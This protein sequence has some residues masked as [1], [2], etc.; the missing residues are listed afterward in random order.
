V[1]HAAAVGGVTGGCGV[2]HA[3][4]AEV[5]RVVGGI[6][7]CLASAPAVGDVLG[8]KRRGGG[9]LGDVQAVAGVVVGLDQVDLAERADRRDHVDVEGFLFGP[10]TSGVR[11]GLGGQRRGLAL[12]VVH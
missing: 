12:L 5:L 8:A 3:R 2:D 7:G 11:R 1:D 6:G 4:Y 10:V 9:L